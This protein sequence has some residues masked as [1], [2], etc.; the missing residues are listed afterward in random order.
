MTKN[1]NSRKIFLKVSAL[2]YLRFEK[3][4]KLTF[5]DSRQEEL[6]ALEA[7]Q[8]Y[9]QIPGSSNIRGRSAFKQGSV[10]NESL[11]VMQTGAASMLS[12]IW[13]KAS[14]RMSPSRHGASSKQRHLVAGSKRSSKAPGSSIAS[15]K[16]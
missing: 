16:K 8:Q 9:S 14:M 2:V 3:N 5:E 12:S 4:C 7:S 10:F 1:L 15:K 13:G 11:S 6:D